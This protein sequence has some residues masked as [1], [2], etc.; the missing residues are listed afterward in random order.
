VTSGT[1]RTAGL[2]RF[3][4]PLYTV[5]EAARYVDVPDSTLR[6][7]THGYRRRATDRPD[8]MGA[9]ILTTLPRRHP[10]SPVIP[11]IGLAEG[12]VLAAMRRSGVPL[13]RIRPA[14]T[15]LDTEFGLAHALASQRLFTDGAE[16]LFD[17][18]EGSA[19]EAAARAVRDLVVVRNGQRVF[20]EVVDSYLRR[21]EFA[22]DGYARLVRLP[23]YTVAEV[24][25]DAGRGFGQ[26]VFAHGGVRLEDAL[27]MFRAGDSLGVVAREYGIPTNELEDAVRV[28]TRIAA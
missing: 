19:D 1:M 22:A 23:A 7:W 18:A 26:P 14:L 6:S 3:A 17:Y 8:V 27:A 21:L 4:V 2:D 24:V 25:V 28:A 16:V 20:N 13:Q 5:A 12:L 11:F 15:Q 10:Q 9:A